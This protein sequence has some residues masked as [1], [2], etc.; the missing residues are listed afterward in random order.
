MSKKHKITNLA[1]ES[2]ERCPSRFSIDLLDLHLQDAVPSSISILPATVGS[3]ED[4]HGI[5]LSTTLGNIESTEVQPLRSSPGVESNLITIDA[6]EGR[7]EVEALL[8]KSKVGNMIWY[9]MKWVGF[10]DKDNT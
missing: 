10:W 1:K 7:W 9:L 2:W 3:T 8:A 5:I 4:A 6:T